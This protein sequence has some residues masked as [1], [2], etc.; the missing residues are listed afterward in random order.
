MAGVVVV[1]VLEMV[2]PVVAVVIQKHHL[3][4]FRALQVL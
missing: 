4:E 2:Q 3:L 1:A